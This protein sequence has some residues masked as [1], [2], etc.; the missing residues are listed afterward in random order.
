MAK[1]TYVRKQPTVQGEVWDPSKGA[2]PRVIM[3]WDCRV[4][5]LEPGDV[6]GKCGEPWSEHG[7]T[8]SGTACP[9]LMLMDFGNGHLESM[10]DEE[11]EAGWE[12]A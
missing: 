3:D 12:L 1:R 9:G 8:T 5:S 7:L 11:V 4:F 2:D 10:T 6:D